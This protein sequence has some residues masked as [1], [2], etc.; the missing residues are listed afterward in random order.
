VSTNYTAAVSQFGQIGYSIEVKRN[1]TSIKMPTVF[2]YLDYRS[3]ATDSI[4]FLRW[5]GEYST[6]KFARKAGFKSSSFV[7][8][9]LA[10][11]R[12][13]TANTAARLGKGLGLN[14]D[15]I[16]YL[17]ILVAFNHTKELSEKDRLYRRLLRL[18][19]LK[20]HTKTSAAAHEYYSRWQNVAVLEA[21][22]T[23]WSFK[24]RSAMADDLGME[25][26]EL[27]SIFQTL[28]RLG[29]IEKK[30]N[31]FCPKNTVLETP[32]ELESFNVRRFHSE[33]I[34]LALAYTEDGEPNHGSLAAVT[35]ALSE[36][37]YNEACQMIDGFARELNRLLSG[38]S[39][40]EAVY[41]INFQSFPILKLK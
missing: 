34:K 29:L 27:A 4:D 41:Q 14:K 31:L 7:R 21:L 22:Q 35:I 40:A 37:K 9:L 23:D 39:K 18:K 13:L 1:P 32:P 8:M 3:F 16:S 20:R 11:Q 5:K 10:G 24:S 36:E 25:Q 38:D 17:K 2:D 28:L 26:N 30:G 12:N 19:K 15:E 6:R 33:M